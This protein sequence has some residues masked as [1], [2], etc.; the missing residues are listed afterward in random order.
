MQGA[1]WLLSIHQPQ[2]AIKLIN[3]W[4]NEG[5]D[6]PGRAAFVNRCESLIMGKK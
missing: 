6:D 1:E 4:R 2:M 3:K 5:W